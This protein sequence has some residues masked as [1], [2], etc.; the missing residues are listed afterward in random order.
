MV[1]CKFTAKKIRKIY[2][3]MTSKE[4][5][6]SVKEV[7]CNKIFQERYAKHVKEYKPIAEQQE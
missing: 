3:S 1:L 5:Q 4:I 2:K 7:L 6:S